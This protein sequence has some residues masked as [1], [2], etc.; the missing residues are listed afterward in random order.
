MLLTAGRRCCCGRAAAGGGRAGP[1]CP[2]RQRP[3]PPWRLQ[4][5]RS[6]WRG[7]PAPASALDAAGSAG[8][9]AAAAAAQPSPAA[10]EAVLITEM[11]VAPEAVLTLEEEDEEEEAEGGA[12]AGEQQPPDGPPL[13]E[14]A[15]GGGAALAASA[16]A[17]GPDVSVGSTVP[18]PG[19]SPSPP[20]GGAAAAAA[21]AG[22]DAA[23]LSHAERAAAAQ[24]SP[25]APELITEML[26]AP[27]AVLTLEEEDEEEEEE[28]EGGAVA[29][30]QQPPDGAPL[31]E[32]ASDVGAALA[33]SAAADGSDV[34]VGGT[35]PSPGP[36][37]GSV[38]STVPSPGPSPSPPLGGAAAAAAAASASLDD[39]ELS[40]AERA[41]AA[42]A[43]AARLR[44]KPAPVPPWW[45]P[46]EYAA[47]V[48]LAVSLALAG[49]SNALLC[50]PFGGYGGGSSRIAR[51]CSSCCAPPAAQA[52]HRVYMLRAP[53]RALP[54]LPL[55][56]RQQVEADQLPPPSYRVPSLVSLP[57]QAEAEGWQAH[58]VAAREWFLGRL[59]Y[60]LQ[61]LAAAP[62]GSKVL[63]VALA[64]L[65]FIAVF[66]ALYA[67]A[68]RVQ[69]GAAMYKVYALLYRVPGIGIAKESN[70]AAYAVANA[71]FLVG[72]FSFAAILGIVS[73]EIKQG[74]RSSRSGNYTLRTSGH[75]LLLN[76]TST[77]CA[78]IRQIASAYSVRAPRAPEAPGAAPRRARPR[79][80]E[81]HC[82]ARVPP[83]PPPPPPPP[84]PPQPGGMF[85][86]TS[87]WPWGGRAPAVVVLAD[88][89]KAWMD[90]AVHDMLRDRGLKLEVHT[91][92][93][94]PFKLSDLRRVAASR[95]STII[96][97]H[98]E[99]ASAAHAEALKASAAMAITALDPSAQQRVVVQM[100][101][102]SA[103][104]SVASSLG[105]TTRLVGRSPIHS[106][107]L[108]DRQL[109]MRL[110]AQ[111]AAQPGIL[112]CWLDVLALAT[113]SAQFSSAEMPASLHGLPYRDVRRTPGQGGSVQLNPSED[114]VP[115]PGSSLIFLGRGG[116]SSLVVAPD[117][118]V[119]KAAAASAAERLKKERTY[120]S[121]PRSILVAGWP[122][123][124]VPD[125]CESFA[126]FTPSGTVVTLT[127]AGEPAP[128]WPTR[129]GSCRFVF[130]PNPH[131][132]SVKA[133]LEAGIKGADAVVLGSGAAGGGE[134]EQD[135]G[136]LAA[137]LQVQDAVLASKRREPPPHLVAPIRRYATSKLAAQYLEVLAAEALGA[138]PA[139]APGAGRQPAA[140]RPVEAAP[141]AG[142]EPPAGGATGSAAAGA[143]GPAAAPAPAAPPSGGGLLAA[144][145][146][147]SG[148]GGG[149]GGGGAAPAPAPPG[150]HQLVLSGA[151]FLVPADV[152]SALLTQVVSDASWADIT[153]SL[154]F[155]AKGQE[156]YLRNPASFNLPTN[157]QPL[158]FAE[159][160]EAVRLTGQTALG[161]TR[162]GV[163][164][165]AGAG[166]RARQAAPQRKVVLGPAASHTVVFDES[167]R[168]VVLAHDFNRRPQPPQAAAGQ[169]QPP[170]S[171]NSSKS[172][173]RSADESRVAMGKLGSSSLAAA[174]KRKTHKERSQPAA[175]KKYGLLEKKK[176]YL[177]RAKD[178][179]RK[180]KTIKALQGK[181]EQ[182]NPDEFYFAMEKAR[183]K[184]GVHIARSTQANKYTQAELLL[185]KTQD[186]K[187]VGLKSRTE[188][189]KA[190]RLRASLHFIG[191]AAP[192]RHTVFVDSAA[193]AAAFEPAEFFDTPAELLGRTYN[194]PRNAQLAQ[195]PLAPV[196]V[197]EATK[198]E[199]RKHAAYKELS[200]RLER[201]AKLGGVAASMAAAKELMGKGR[202][203]KLAAADGSGQAVFRWKRER[204]K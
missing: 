79:P 82:A 10:P 101:G 55:P 63:A 41:A 76:W 62:V 52:A 141:A 13:A 164:A 53:E 200:Q 199:R 149:G 110:V 95:A 136:I 153:Q 126:Q 104:E 167:D 151:E 182:R 72:L 35:V 134:Q 119:Y 7:R 33:A 49:M 85:R 137:V 198:A 38:G 152:S 171:G 102:P 191:A 87:I 6:R 163:P 68:A 156:L 188:A 166:G 113:N 157:G 22:L 201:S 186:V 183:T 96:V 108:P 75:I 59:A 58:V 12:V 2:A 17:G 122:A 103:D 73:D 5:P 172:R 158:S 89:D 138:G 80:P 48:G 4:Q 69:L 146:G 204:K 36:S 97:L 65:P 46:T 187:Y 118:G 120:R 115:P 60:N 11:L 161:W 90:S 61:L 144:L 123:A 70:A 28:A 44:V 173:R 177:L 159:V 43:T 34:S 50:T 165:A 106:L 37:P 23:E 185:M 180:E 56:L 160:E 98:P 15:S 88:K 139:A 132:T 179:H 105:I 100:T 3:L 8:D 29:G 128:D 125:L 32:E 64:A 16:A 133:L 40:H 135:A 39:A 92:Q 47:L 24:A 57:A 14:E 127:V 178:Y 175:R 93:G 176:D 174:V 66:G 202:K 131:P 196:S 1:A 192:A 145:V 162:P 197:R 86:S 99:S 74:I 9:A 94:S 18:S 84:P 154:L 83:M 142:S 42:A 54:S 181:A 116:A 25:A 71:A 112:T 81:Q 26:V 195:Q 114:E 51:Q 31:A 67:V 91:R 124:S 45:P 109:T 184:D 20:Q 77:S 150:G 147:G 21:S 169:Q 170:R 190:E 27:E 193:E 121:K 19:P 148:T 107:E 194:R 30:E 129:L 111:T 130:I 78:L 117:G 140:P 155:D 143:A 203:R 189:A 168:I